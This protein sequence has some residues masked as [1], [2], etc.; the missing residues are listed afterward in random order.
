MFASNAHA[1]LV[2]VMA[3][4]LV[5]SF[6]IIITSCGSAA[7]TSNPSPASTPTAIPTS[8]PTPTP[9]NTP[10][11]NVSDPLSSD[12]AKQ[13][14]TQMATA[15]K[16]T[17]YTTL[18]NMTSSEYQANHSQQQMTDDIQKFIYA[19]NNEGIAITD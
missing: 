13:V 5:L 6:S 7:D 12:A 2:V 9:T 10:T 14:F 3:S 15:I 1:R 16:N 4:I 19:P 18:Y 11:A 8:P 17:D